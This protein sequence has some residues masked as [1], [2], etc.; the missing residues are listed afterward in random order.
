MYLVSWYRCCCT[1]KRKPVAWLIFLLHDNKRL[2]RLHDNKVG[3]RLCCTTEREHTENSNLD[4]A[5]VSHERQ[6]GFLIPLLLT[7]CPYCLLSL[8][9]CSLYYN[10]C[11]LLVHTSARRAGVG[12]SVKRLRYASLLSLV[13]TKRLLLCERLLRFIWFEGIPNHY[14]RRRANWR[15][16]GFQNGRNAY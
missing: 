7:H 8:P 14:Y 16:T 10:S 13:E 2:A 11:F 9:V 1:S 15:S 5:T 12:G 3:T 4:L 6:L